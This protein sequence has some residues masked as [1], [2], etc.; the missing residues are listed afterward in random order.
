MKALYFK[1]EAGDRGEEERDRRRG[2]GGMG[3]VDVRSGM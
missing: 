2:E 1:R 3:E